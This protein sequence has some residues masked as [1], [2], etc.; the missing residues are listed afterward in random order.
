MNKFLNFYPSFCAFLFFALALIAPSGYSYGPILLLLA[1]L[2]LMFSKKN[3][4]NID[5]QSLSL[6]FALLC[7]GTLWILEVLIHHSESNFDKPIRYLLAAVALLF[8]LRFPPKAK[9]IWLGIAIGAMGTGIFAIII[10]LTSNID[11]VSGFSHNAIQYGNISILLGFLS[12]TGIWWAL[13]QDKHKY[14]WTFFLTAGF[15]LGLIASLLSGSRGGWISAPIIFSFILFYSRHALTKKLTVA[16]LIM[17][18]SLIAIAYLIPSTGVKHR[19]DQVFLQIDQYQDGHTKTSIGTRFEFWKAAL[20]AAKEKPILGWGKPDYLEKLQEL[21]NAKIVSPAIISDPHNMYL[22]ALAFQ[23]IIGLAALLALFILPL[24]IFKRS[25]N[26]HQPETLPLS[27]AGITII[28][29]YVD[30]GLTQTTLKFSSGTTFFCFSIIFIYAA[31]L[32]EKKKLE[33]PASS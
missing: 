16:I 15:I 28:V 32:G 6:L 3:Y 2:P 4:Q 12:L 24:Q 20:I 30:F 5:K 9:A 11:R 27:I 1:A 29:A 33:L 13:Q 19:T 8:L 7:F 14:I 31:L 23:G 17:F 26:A 18:G 21:V 25:I 22:S 10:K